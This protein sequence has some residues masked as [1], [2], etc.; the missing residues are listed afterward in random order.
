MKV[1]RLKGLTTY[2][3]LYGLLKL[4]QKRFQLSRYRY[5]LL[6]SEGPRCSKK[7]MTSKSE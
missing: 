2:K 3:W 6:C 5:C 7:E 4:I 1:I